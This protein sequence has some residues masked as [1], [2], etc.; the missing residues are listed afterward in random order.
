MHNADCCACSGCLLWTTEEA[1][2]L[3]SCADPIRLGFELSDRHGLRYHS[4][5]I[6][7]SGYA[8]TGRT[9]G[10]HSVP[11]ARARMRSASDSPRA[12]TPPPRNGEIHRP[13]D[14]RF[15]RRKMALRVQL[16]SVK[17][18]NFDPLASAESPSPR[19]RNPIRPVSP[20][21]NAFRGLLS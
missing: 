16:P 12:T 6:D 9:I 4:H 8:S 18:A 17:L 20:Q 14:C 10:A 13:L 21:A 3:P 7:K 2:G 19:F 15:G 1:C 5:D 11:V